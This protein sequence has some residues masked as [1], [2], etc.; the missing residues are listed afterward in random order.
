MCSHCRYLP[1]SPYS[2]SLR[3]QRIYR[4]ASPQNYII[5]ERRSS[6]RGHR[7][8]GTYN[9]FTSELSIEAINRSHGWADS[10]VLNQKPVRNCDRAFC[11]KL[12]CTRN[13][14]RLSCSEHRI[15]VPVL[16]PAFFLS[17]SRTHPPAG[18][19]AKRLQWFHVGGDCNRGGKDDWKLLYSQMVQSEIR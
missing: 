4:V 14:H 8:A 11:S 17:Q 15:G 10:A 7:N 13:D 5:R 12:S 2:W 16:K 3:F 19:S 6:S 9:I 1:S 18:Y